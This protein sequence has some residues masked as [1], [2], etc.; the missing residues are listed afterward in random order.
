MPVTARF[1]LA[2]GG[3]AEPDGATLRQWLAE[4]E[5]NAA[6]QWQVVD[7]TS[8]V[9]IVD[10]D[11]D[12]ASRVLAERRFGALVIL[13]LR[14][15]EAAWPGTLS[16]ARPF[17]PRQVDLTLNLAA[18][19]IAQPAFTA[20]TPPA[21]L[22]AANVTAGDL[23]DALEDAGTPA[24][25]D[26]PLFAEAV[27]EAAVT[28]QEQAIAE[29]VEDTAEATRADADAADDAA[30]DRL[31]IAVM[32][33]TVIP[34]DTDA[35]DEDADEN[36]TDDDIVELSAE[37]APSIELLTFPGPDDDPMAA[38][39]SEA[40]ADAAEPVGSADDDSV[41]LSSDFADADAALADADRASEGR[42]GPFDDLLP[43]A[44]PAPVVEAQPDA[45]EDTHAAS[46]PPPIVDPP[47]PTLPEPTVAL[48]AIGTLAELATAY[49]E[50]LYRERHVVVRI[51]SHVF[52]L[53]PYA[54]E[55]HSES[56]AAALEAYRGHGNLNVTIAIEDAA[57]ADRPATA[58]PLVEFLWQLGYHAGNA[59]LLP[60]VDAEA[61]YRITRQP[62]MGD[63]A[64]ETGVLQLAQLI[65][66]T[67]VAVADMARLSGAGEDVVSDFL[68]GCS[69]LG[70]LERVAQPQRRRPAGDPPP[71][72]RQTSPSLIGTLR[73]R[74][75]LEKS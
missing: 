21:T 19:I 33:G 20:Q 45:P 42:P 1:R 3:L 30:I 24:A 32:D 62:P 75:G 7:D 53:H 71:A 61:R 74:I 58:L 17:D 16:M 54:G 64:K 37:S 6:A 46:A 39:A 2:L 28:E 34:D 5:L 55:C 8:D 15:G 70:Y 13:A 12:N 57:A 67:P 26:A 23:L 72:R 22:P 59:E 9:V 29:E 40:P 14:P 43:P 41:M 36:R 31:A 63:D 35:D 27:E 73:K 47:E 56:A 38:F 68:N 51:D 25:D 66:R 49:R 50:Q 65:S 11:A 52:H 69:L 10:P 44:P 60:W 18:Q 4:G 48:D